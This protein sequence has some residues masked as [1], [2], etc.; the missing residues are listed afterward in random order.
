MHLFAN[1]YLKFA[2]KFRSIIF[3]IDLQ[4]TAKQGFIASQLAPT[5]QPWAAAS[6]FA[7]IFTNYLIAECQPSSST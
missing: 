4:W 7:D 5:L 1:L 3:V 6:Q 2:G